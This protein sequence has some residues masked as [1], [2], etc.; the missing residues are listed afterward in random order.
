MD[1]AAAGYLI[2]I[3]WKRG[4]DFKI[5][6]QIWKSSNINSVLFYSVLAKAQAE[7]DAEAERVRLMEQEAAARLG[8]DNDS[9]LSSITNP[10]DELSS[11][12]KKVLTVHVVLYLFALL[13]ICLHHS[14]FCC[15]WIFYAWN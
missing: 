11:K 13:L 5:Y 12:A 15:G 14:I 4:R 10:D 6:W 8:V 3:N 7:A 1:A 2:I 9:V